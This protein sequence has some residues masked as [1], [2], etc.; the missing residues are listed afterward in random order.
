MIVSV[1]ILIAAIFALTW[2]FLPDFYTG[3]GLRHDVSLEN[4]LDKLHSTAVAQHPQNLT[5]WSVTWLNSTAARVNWAFTYVGRVNETT[6]QTTKSDYQS[7]QEHPLSRE[8]RHDQ[9]LRH[10][11]RLQLR[12]EH[13]QHVHA[14]E[15]HLRQWRC[16]PTGLWTPPLHVRRLQRQGGTRQIH[17]AIRPVRAG[18]QLDADDLRVTGCSPQARHRRTFTA[19]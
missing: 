18:R 11:D 14:Y 9:L 4:Y 1:V 6:N 5:A 3:L 19:R 17:L 7:E 12:R 13:Q 16:L 2:I 15:Q 8:F 10:E